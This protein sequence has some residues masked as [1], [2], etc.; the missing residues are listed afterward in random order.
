MVH[1]LDLDQLG[2]VSPVAKEIQQAFDCHLEHLA[3]HEAA[4]VT[5]KQ[6]FHLRRLPKQALKDQRR[7]VTHAFGDLFQ[8]LG[9]DRG[10]GHSC[11]ERPGRSVQARAI[12]GVQRTGSTVTARH[13]ANQL[14]PIINLRP[15]ES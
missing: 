10:V 4:D 7:R 14:F 2:A 12:R 5:D 8:R 15:N 9:D 1:A 3:S 11:R 13:A 6:R